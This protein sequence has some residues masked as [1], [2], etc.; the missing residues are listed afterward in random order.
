MEAI[1]SRHHGRDFKPGEISKE[2]LGKLIDAEMS[3]PSAMH[4][5][6]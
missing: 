2:I 4:F 1:L 5:A 3:A 6:L